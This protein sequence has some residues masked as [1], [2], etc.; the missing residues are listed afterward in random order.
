MGNILRFDTVTSYTE[1]LGQKTQHPFVA[2]IDLSKSPET[3]HG[4]HAFGFYCIFL[5]EIKCGN[6][7]YGC[8]YYDYQEGTLVFIAPG[9]ISGIEDNGEKF[10]PQGYA[11]MFHP[12]ILRG[13][14]LGRTINRYTFFSYQS[15][16]ALHLTEQERSTVLNCMQNIAAELKYETDSHSKR[17][18]VSN[19]ELFLNYCLRFYDRQFTTRREANRGILAR[20][21]EVLNDYF[22]SGK[23]HPEGLPTVKYC[24]AKLNLSPNYFG[25]LIKKETGKSA[26]EHI[27]DKLMDMAKEKIYDTEKTISEIAYELGF[28]YP[29]HFSRLFKKIAGITP[30]EYRAG[31]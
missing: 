31:R 27:Q 29:Q 17:L 7:R 30:K 26:S 1:Y 15:N 5:K 21:E 18:I 4:L 22:T 8:N 10:K 13:T 25:D 19:V 24:A 20:F 16:E 6:L 9:Q 12:D 23:Q 2:V 3:R 14:P 28:R 11:L